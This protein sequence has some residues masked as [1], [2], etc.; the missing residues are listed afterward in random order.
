MTRFIYDQFS[1]DYLET[2][3]GTYGSVEVGKNVAGEIREIDLWFSPTSPPLPSYLGLLGRLAESPCLFEPYHNPVT[4]EEINDCLLKLLILRGEVLREAKRQ[5]RR[6]SG[7]ILPKLW[8]LTPTASQKLL[9]SFGG[10][11]KPDWTEGIYFLPDSLRTA[12]VV[13]HHLPPSAETLCLRLLGRGKVQ[14]K[15][16]DEIESLP[17]NHPFRA[18]SLELLYNLRRN[19][20]RLEEREQEAR[21]LIMRLAPLYQQD[22]EQAV[23]EGIQQGVQQGIQQGVQQGEVNL[24]L[25]LLNRRLGSIPANLEQRIRQL[26]VEQLEELGIAFL[27]FEGETDLVNWL[28][29]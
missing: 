8:I 24:L 11:F 22:R 7:V 3:L 26:S 23:R 16:I 28:N 6:L 5:K 21:E 1:K 4:T 14:Q 18:V 2:L 15:A 25:R 10:Q 9:R 19:L 27:D 12:L 20:E 13:I 29:E 17:S